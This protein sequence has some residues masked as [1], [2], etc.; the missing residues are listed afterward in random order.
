MSSLPELSTFEVTGN[1]AIPA[2]IVDRSRSE[3]A[4][5]GYARGWSQG[6]RDARDSVKDARLA[7]A[8][9]QQAFL[10]T[11]NAAAAAALQALAQAADQLEKAALPGI[12]GH[13]ETI[14]SAAIDIA[15]ALLGQELRHHDTATRAAI[16]RC[17]QLAPRGET[18]SIRLNADVLATLGEGDI[19]NLLDSITGAAG[20][21]IRLE[22]DP[23]LAVGD[24]V[25][26]C[27]A[28]T[29]DAR[30]GEGIGRIRAQLSGTEATGRASG[31]GSGAG[32]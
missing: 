16:A 15:E 8:A 27:G 11:R 21:E 31:S 22:S 13:E 26:R 12:S 25:A 3:A 1:A 6:I 10:L 19:T 28:S 14:L 32:A 17:L 29:I 20:R 18:V 24:A 30:L 5:V 9:E 23:T 2:A 4:A 7:A